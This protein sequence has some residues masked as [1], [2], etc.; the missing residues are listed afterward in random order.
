[1]TRCHGADP[2]ARPGGRR[3]GGGAGRLQSVSADADRSRAAGPRQC[4]RLRSG[5]VARRGRQRACRPECAALA[6]ASSNGSPPTCTSGC[7][8]GPRATEEELSAYRGRGRVPALP[9]LRGRLVRAH[10][11]GR[12]AANGAPRGSAATAAS[13]ATSRISSRS[14]PDAA[15][16]PAHLFALGFQARR[17]FHHIFRQIFG[18]SLPA[19]RLR[20]AVWQSI[21]THDMPALSR[22]AL[23]PH[24]RHPDADHRR[25]G[26]RQGAGGARHRPVAL[27]PVRPAHADV[28][29]R[30]RPPASVRS[31]CRR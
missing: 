6:R 4:V 12:A 16:D 7:A 18:G 26:Y 31:T 9:A 8:T 27:S 17:A 10:R 21:F 22:A 29:R 3:R 11:S 25:I 1:M 30:S 2:D 19:A 15:V 23:R 24:G 20:A 14:L 13:R 28:C 5:G